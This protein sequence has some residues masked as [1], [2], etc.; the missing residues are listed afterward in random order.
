MDDMAGGMFFP[1][2]ECN[3]GFITLTPNSGIFSES[4][5]PKD[6]GG[7]LRLWDQTAKFTPLMLPERNPAPDVWKI[8]PLVWEQVKKLGE[9]RQDE[10]VGRDILALNVKD[11]GGKPFILFTFNAGPRGEGWVNFI[12]K[13]QKEGSSDA[14]VMLTKGEKK[15]LNWYLDRE[16]AEELLGNNSDNGECSQAEPEPVVGTKR[17]AD[18][19]GG[20]LE[21]LN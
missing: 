15:S 19:L 4:I 11:D 18:D 5:T 9:S 14:R 20:S 3:N 13:K 21:R 17:K 16:D 10:V 2:D 8:E 12:G 1:D 7:S 6:A